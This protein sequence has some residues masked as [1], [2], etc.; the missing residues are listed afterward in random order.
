MDLSR[1]ALPLAFSW[2]RLGP[3]QRVPSGTLHVSTVHVTAQT[4]PSMGTLMRRDS[5]LE[6]TD[7][8]SR[9][10]GGVVSRTHHH[11]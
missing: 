6:L 8:G 11:A 4:T 1:A 10:S 7:P 9:N 3:E 2:K 5:R